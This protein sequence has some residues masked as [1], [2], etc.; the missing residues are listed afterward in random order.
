[1]V[2]KHASLRGL[3]ASNW[4]ESGRPRW[5]A[6]RTVRETERADEQLRRQGLDPASTFRAKRLRQDRSY[7]RTWTMGCHFSWLN[8]R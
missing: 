8:P 7:V 5:D 6:A 4:E 2:K 3:V 1:M